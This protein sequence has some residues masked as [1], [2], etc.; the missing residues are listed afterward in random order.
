M[1]ASSSA[2]FSFLVTQWIGT[3]QPVGEYRPCLNCRSNDSQDT[4]SHEYQ[5]YGPKTIGITVGYQ[6]PSKA[7]SS[8]LVV[9]RFLGFPLEDLDLVAECVLLESFLAQHERFFAEV[10]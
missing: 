10:H 2:I 8:I 7:V 6:Q 9:F 1:T 5:E 4:I 3:T